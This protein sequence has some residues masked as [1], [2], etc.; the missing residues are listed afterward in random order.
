MLTQ[1]SS[2]PHLKKSDE[3]AKRFIEMR[4]FMVNM[5]GEDFSRFLSAER[6]SKIED[7]FPG[8]LGVVMNIRKNSVG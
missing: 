2:M 8:L 4:D 3:A 1:Q 5:N 7:R 6:I